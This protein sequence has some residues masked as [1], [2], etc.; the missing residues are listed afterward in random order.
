MSDF[1]M[2]TTRG[3]IFVVK[4]TVDVR[5]YVYGRV[6]LMEDFLQFNAVH[7]VPLDF[8]RMAPSPEHAI[9]YERD[10]IAFKMARA[11]VEHDGVMRWSS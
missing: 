2:L 6:P 9:K 7:A 5:D 11:I 3:E 8:L 1:P 4:N 10:G